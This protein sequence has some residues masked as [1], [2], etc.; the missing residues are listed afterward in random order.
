MVL[1]TTD[2]KQSGNSQKHDKNN[3]RGNRGS[4]NRQQNEVNSRQQGRNEGQYNS[5]PINLCGLCSVIKE[6]EV[7]QEYVNQRFKDMHWSVTDRVIYANQCL[8]WMML[9]MDDRIKDIQKSDIFCRICLRLLGMEAGASGRAC[10]NGKHIKGNG[11]NM[12]CVQSDCDT[13]AT[14]CKRHERINTE[15]QSCTAL[16]TT[17]HQRS[18]PK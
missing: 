14:L 15:K 5:Q 1:I 16:E 2:D 11:R 3:S 4:N 13:N 7:S 9:S 18:N 6:N 10:S 8:P 12:S 17:G